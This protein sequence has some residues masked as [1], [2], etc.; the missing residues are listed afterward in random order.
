M[1]ESTYF[2][3]KNKI[4]QNIRRKLYLANRRQHCMWR[5]FREQI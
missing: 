1:A 4:K 3:N 5:K 2:K